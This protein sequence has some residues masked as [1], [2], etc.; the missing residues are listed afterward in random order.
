MLRSQH[1]LGLTARL[2][3]SCASPYVAPLP[4][5]CEPN[6]GAVA[7]MMVLNLPRPSLPPRGRI[8]LVNRGWVPP[9]WRN[10]WAAGVAAQQPSGCMRATGV[11]QGSESPSGFMPDSNLGEKQFLWV[12]VPSLVSA[13]RGAGP[14]A[15]G[16][17][18]LPH[19]PHRHTQERGVWW[20]A[21]NYDTV[22]LDR[23]D[24]E[25]RS[26]RAEAEAG[27]AGG[28]WPCLGSLH[29]TGHV[30]G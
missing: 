22:M 5:G 30:Q 10:G 11:V 19:A 12:D 7:H 2:G 20:E 28:G 3:G 1:Q 24:R 8:I 18:V 21:R 29:N 4:T 25:G 27:K 14:G 9:R 13:R 17:S 6:C 16:D 26:G 23:A 15:F